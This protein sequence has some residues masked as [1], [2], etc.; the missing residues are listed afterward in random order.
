MICSVLVNIQTHTQTSYIYT[1]P[2]RQTA[3]WPAVTYTLCVRAGRHTLL[4]KGTTGLQAYWACEGHLL[5][6]DTCG[7][8]S[9]GH[10]ASNGYTRRTSADVAK[11][12]VTRPRQIWRS[13]QDSN[14]CGQSPMDFCRS[15]VT[16]FFNN[17]FGKFI[18]CFIGHKRDGMVV[19]CKKWC[20]YFS[21]I[22][23]QFHCSSLR[24]CQLVYLPTRSGGSRGAGGPWPPPLAAWKIFFRLYINIITKPTAYDGPWEY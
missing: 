22:F 13:R 5:G 8:T 15:L 11:K 12:V 1:H 23:A 9:V 19:L 14:L 4:A 16:T 18:S 2:D 17:I 6:L 20:K 3:F 7:L 10:S 24:G 21:Q